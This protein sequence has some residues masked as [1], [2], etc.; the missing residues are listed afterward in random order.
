MTI[1]LSNDEIA[2]LLNMK[3]VLEA[4]ETAYLEAAAG[5]A[6]LGT[7]AEIITETTH[8]ESVYQLKMMS[9]SISSLGVGAVRINSDILSF[10]TVGGKNDERRCR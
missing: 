6:I 5:R 2:C 10:P 8:P 3:D 9:S 7:R 4:L 1:L